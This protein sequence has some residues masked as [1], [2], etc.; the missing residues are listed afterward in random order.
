[1]VDFGSMEQNLGMWELLTGRLFGLDVALKCSSV[2]CEDTDHELGGKIIIDLL[3]E[4]ADDAIRQ[5]EASVAETAFGDADRT[6]Y[7]E[8]LAS[9]S[10]L[11]TI[12]LIV[13]SPPP[14]WPRRN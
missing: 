3:D 5:L 14:F 4:S 8:L 13:K 6:V 12:V 9:Q 7:E 1:M 11:P 10:R 2:P